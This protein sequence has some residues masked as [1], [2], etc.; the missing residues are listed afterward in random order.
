MSLSCSRFCSE[1]LTATRE[2]YDNAAA[3]K[4]RPL[5]I[6]NG[7]LD[8]LRG[9]Y[10]PSWGFPELAKLSKEFLPQVEC[11]YFIHNFKGSRPGKGWMVG[12]PA[13]GIRHLSAGGGGGA[14]ELE[15]PHSAGKCC[16]GCKRAATCKCCTLCCG[17][18]A[19]A[20]CKALGCTCVKYTPDSCNAK[21][22]CS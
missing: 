15:Q 17:P 21:G 14:R 9:G 5:I 16:K 12:L 11:A 18:H 1:E 22:A 8:R 7:E 20:P 2:L 4:D 10:Y 3:L 13:F 6:F 19:A